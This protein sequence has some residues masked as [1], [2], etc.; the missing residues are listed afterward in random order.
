MVIIISDFPKPK[1]A[2]VDQT[3]LRIHAVLKFL[4]I[5]RTEQNFT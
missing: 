3:F 4:K 2:L 1:M 5:Y